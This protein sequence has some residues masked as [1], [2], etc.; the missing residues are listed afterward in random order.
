MSFRRKGSGGS[1]AY[2]SK[3]IRGRSGS[4]GSGTGSSKDE[5]PFKLVLVNE[6]RAGADPTTFERTATT[7]ALERFFKVD[8][9]IFVF[10]T[11]YVSY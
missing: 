10:K 8:E 1:N 2:E 3:L 4:A 7:P 5:E 11:H 6:T 9:N